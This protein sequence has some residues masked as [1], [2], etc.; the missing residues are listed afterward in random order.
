MALK[1]EN[2]PEIVK[3]LDTNFPTADRLSLEPETLRDMISNLPGIDE[4]TAKNADEDF[5][6]SILINWMNIDE[7]NGGSDSPFD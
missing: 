4:D 7:N 5:L 6:H 3:A 2:I 1:W